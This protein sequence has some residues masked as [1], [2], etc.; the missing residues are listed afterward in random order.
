MPVIGSPITITGTATTT[1]ADPSTSTSERVVRLVDDYLD[2]V[3]HDFRQLR[4]WDEHARRDGNDPTILRVTYK[5]VSSNFTPEV[6]DAQNTAIAT[7]GVTWDYPNGEFSVTADDGDQDYFVTY[8]FNQFPATDLEAMLNLTLM[9]INS[10][11]EPG[12]HL[13]DYETIEDAPTYWDGPLVI[14]T[15]AKCFRRLATDGSLWANFLIWQDG[16]TGQQIAQQAS[17]E[18]QTLFD[19]LRK[20]V[21]RTHHIA[22]LTSTFSYFRAIGFGGIGLYSS[23]FRGLQINRIGSY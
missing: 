9:E 22:Q 20:S 1:S 8:E 11:A 21:K 19:D 17:Q 13:T 4:V 10:S 5:P 15:L 12:T 2:S 16:A 18:Y 14:G 23:R 6:Y 7:A 3:L